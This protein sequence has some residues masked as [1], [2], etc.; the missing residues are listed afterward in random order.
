MSN[1]QQP[2]TPLEVKPLTSEDWIARRAYEASSDPTVQRVVRDHLLYL[3]HFYEADRQQ[4]HG[5]IAELERQLAA[6]KAPDS[7]QSNWTGIRAGLLKG[8]IRE[9]YAQPVAPDPIAPAFDDALAHASVDDL[10]WALNLLIT[11]PHSK[12]TYRKR[13]MTAIAARL[14]ELAGKGGAD[15]TG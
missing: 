11:H 12:R 14:Q 15:A 13:R 5:R 4:L 3:R 2:P 1:E 8:R 6:A 10:M 9:Q 7:K